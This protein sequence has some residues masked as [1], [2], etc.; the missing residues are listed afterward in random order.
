MGSAGVLQA[1]LTVALGLFGGAGATLVWE[2]ALRPGRTRRSVAK[3]LI[4]ELAHNRSQLRV[5][6]ELRAENPPDSVPRSTDL[7]AAVYDAAG[8]DL[9]ELSL[10]TLTLVH[11]AYS[12]MRKLEVRSSNY[13]NHLES[14]GPAGATARD[15]ELRAMRIVHFDQSLGHAIDAVE[16][17]LPAL[18]LAALPRWSRRRKALRARVAKAERRMQS[19]QLPDID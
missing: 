4:A 18:E 9:S 12:C 14:L 19:L 15:L 11:W 3:G 16:N 17:A 8:R 1:V 10:R 7:S 5:L 6:A 13:W 2:L